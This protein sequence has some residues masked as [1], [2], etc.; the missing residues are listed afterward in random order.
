MIHIAY[1]P[2]LD[3]FH[4]VYRLL[5][6]R[7]HLSEIEIDKC[8]ILDFYMVFPFW[9]QNI[10]F[11]RGDAALKKVG[12]SYEFRRGYALLPPARSL[13]ESMKPVFD[14]SIQT[15]ATQGYLTQSA[16][17][18]GLVSM[19]EKDVPDE[20]QARVSADNAREKDLL[21][22]IASLSTYPLLGNDGLKARTKLMEYRNDAV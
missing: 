7:D 17:I 2:A 16:L 1:Q 21:K 6:I 19:T 22:V 18:A 8:R 10:R 11:Q 5:R 9:T 4:T 13:F 15:L 14:A 12:K 20:I 3:P